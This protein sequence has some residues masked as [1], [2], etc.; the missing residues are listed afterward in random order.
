M[1]LKELLSTLT[2]VRVEG[3]PEVE[4]GGVAY[5]SA[6]VRPGDA[7]FALRG[8][9][10]DGHL[11]VPA[12]VEAG[13]RVVFA[14]RPVAVD[15]RTTLVLVPDARAALSLV[16]AALFGDPSKTL[17]MVGVTG[18]KGK[19]TVAYLAH[20][21]LSRRY[22]RVGLI[23]TVSMLAGDRP[24]G[25]QRTTPTTPEGSDLQE[26]LATMVKENC[27]A[28]VMEVSSHALALRRVAGV[29][30]D[31]AVFTNLGRDH[32]DFHRDLDDYLAA[33][34]LLF[35]G[36]GRAYRPPLK[37]GPKTAVINYDDEKSGYMRALVS[38]GCRVLGY[39]MSPAAE[40]T[41]ERITFDQ[42]GVSFRL[43]TPAGDSELGLRLTGRFNVYNALAAV[44][45]GLAEGCRLDE[46]V[47]ALQGFSGV[48]GRFELIDAGQSFSVVVD[49]A[50]T[51]ESLASVLETARELTRGRV[52]SVFGCGG[53]RDR[54]R[55]PI[56]GEVSGR[57]ADLTILTSDN[58]RSEDP[59]RVIDDIEEGIRGV[60]AYERQ[61]DRRLAIRRAISLANPGDLVLI[62]GKGHETYQIFADRTIHFDDR[63]EARQALEVRRDGT[64]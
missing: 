42:K 55:R 64:F 24:I 9:R 51:A 4:V 56:M 18:T 28:C 11:F 60:G 63:E 13:A 19:T 40:I 10:A 48:P 2:G 30:Y 31:T 47:E 34:G 39:G 35:K 16:A 8:E 61:A 23:G 21:V 20:A 26:L 45:V 38:S 54:G 15:D 17:R 37:S 32:L 59:E 7:F 1:L 53:D 33:K 5:H 52:I 29:E 14:E 6:K 3:N 49:Y 44:G 43:K 62:A 46:V 50:H 25:G 27:R 22:Q 57:L 41:A 58:P 36:L 12:A